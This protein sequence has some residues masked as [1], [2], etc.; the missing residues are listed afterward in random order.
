MKRAILSVSDKT[1]IVE[2]AQQLEDKGIEIISTGGT[3]KVLRE[4]GI[5]VISITSFTGSPEVMDGRV[6]TLHPRV[7]AGI[8]YR[9]NNPADV[10]QLAEL[11]AK[12]IDLVV[13]NL[14]PFQQ[15][16]ARPDATHEEIIEN[17]DIGGPSL[18][19]SAA[20]NYASV[21]VLVDPEDYAPFLK[22]LTEG[23]GTVSVEFRERCAAKAFALT[24]VYDRAIAD[25]FASRTKS[26]HDEKDL[27]LHYIKKAKLRYGENPHQAA[28]LYADESY[29]AP[30]LLR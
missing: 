1:G 17:I 2:L 21:T 8:L 23:E 25:Y 29:S 30:T 22:E 20:K 15:T 10:E 12:S 9:R 3:L 16:V 13:V 26:D 24:A 18:I 5:H 6:K 11:D 19:R 7:H 14:Y 28:D 27:N 4:A